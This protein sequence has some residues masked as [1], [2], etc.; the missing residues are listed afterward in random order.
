[1]EFLVVVYKNLLRKVHLEIY[2][3]INRVQAINDIN[4]LCYFHKDLT[5]DADL[6]A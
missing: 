1:M 3:K 4:K 2:F 6:M 5:T